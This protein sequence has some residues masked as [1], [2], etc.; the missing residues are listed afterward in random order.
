M[1]RTYLLFFIALC[2]LVCCQT[3]KPPISIDQMSKVLLDMHLA[4]SYAQQMP[5]PVDHYT[6]K[7]EDSLR[8]YHAGILKKYQ[9]SEKQFLQDLH[10]YTNH[11]TLL[12]SVYQIMLTDIAILQTRNNRD[13]DK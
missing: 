11:P 6:L 7:N 9:L 8:K 2:S 5:K 4:E 3:D 1:I 10:W 12:D 13:Q